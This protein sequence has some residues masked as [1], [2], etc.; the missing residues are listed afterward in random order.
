MNNHI[1][2]I[3][4]IIGSI[5]DIPNISDGI[6]NNMYEKIAKAYATKYFIDRESPDFSNFIIESSFRYKDNVHG[7]MKDPK[8]YYK[9][10]MKHFKNFLFLNDH[11]SE[12]FKESY[13][14]LVGFKDLNGNYHAGLLGKPFNR[15]L[16]HNSQNKMWNNKD[17]KK[18]VYDNLS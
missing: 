9:R 18:K 4:N 8:H 7:F 3:H 5:P 16:Q 10:T 13:K 17:I 12:E 11:N 14:L 1:H 6:P 15:L 2:N